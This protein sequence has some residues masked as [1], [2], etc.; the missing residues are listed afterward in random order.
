MTL[1]TAQRRWSVIEL[2]S[3]TWIAGPLSI[4]SFLKYYPKINIKF[5]NESSMV[6]TLVLPSRFQT[7]FLDTSATFMSHE[8]LTWPYLPFFAFVSI[9]NFL[10]N[11]NWKNLIYII[12]ISVLS[13]CICGSSA[14]TIRAVPDTEL[15]V[16]G[17]APVLIQQVL[18]SWNNK[19][20]YSVL[21]PYSFFS[22]F[23]L[24][25]KLLRIVIDITTSQLFLALKK[26]K[27][28]FSKK[29]LYNLMCTCVDIY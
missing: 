29:L 22:L 16:P 5:P 9:M 7:D 3:I 23:N 15:K 21:K 11:N 24:V 10:I 6:S 13:I 17:L 18:L 8:H 2:L 28:C 26:K 4:H 19:F 14:G 20:G 12:P 1:V 25:L 27:K